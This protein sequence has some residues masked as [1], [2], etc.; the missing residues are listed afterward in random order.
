MSTAKKSY[1]FRVSQGKTWRKIQISK[2]STLEDLHLAIQDVFEFD[3]DH[4]YCFF[5][6]NKR[7]SKDE[8]M[9]FVSS[10]DESGDNLACEAVLQD[11]TFARNQKFMY[12]F[13]YGDEWIFT[14]SLSNEV[15]EETPTPIE[16]AGNGALPQQ[17]PDDE[18]EGFEYDEED[19]ED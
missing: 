8:D 4:L 12:L 19:E 14:V 9:V 15:E 5:M 6:D 13:D 2:K 1:V 7:W 18:H 16:I 11:F 3:N 10:Y 17:Y